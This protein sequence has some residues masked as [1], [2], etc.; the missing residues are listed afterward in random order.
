MVSVCVGIVAAQE[1]GQA[2][3]VAVQRVLMAV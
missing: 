1:T 2:R 3:R